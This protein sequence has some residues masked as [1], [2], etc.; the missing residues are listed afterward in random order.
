MTYER[1]GSGTTSMMQVLY[2]LRAGETSIPIVEKVPV[3]LYTGELAED[4]SVEACRIVIPHSTEQYIIVVCHRA[5]SSHIDSYMVDGTQIFG[6]VVL[7][8]LKDKVKE[9]TVIK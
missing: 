6:E 5:P 1:T 7:I 9:I 3:Y 8:S 4:N 2:P